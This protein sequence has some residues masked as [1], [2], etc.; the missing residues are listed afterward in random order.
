MYQKISYGFK[1]LSKLIINIRNDIIIF[2]FGLQI[3]FI[4]H[5]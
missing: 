1:K 2:L 3:L 4:A 5:R